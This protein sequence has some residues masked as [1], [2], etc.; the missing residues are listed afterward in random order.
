MFFSMFACTFDVCIKLLRTYLLTYLVC[1]KIGDDYFRS[2]VF[3]VNNTILFSKSFALISNFR[4]QLLS[5]A[6]WENRELGELQLDSDET[7]RNLSSECLP[8]A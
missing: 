7:D 5:I 6:A 2:Q 1:K 8:V 4:V 3:T